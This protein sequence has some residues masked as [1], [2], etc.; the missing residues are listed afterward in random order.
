MRE[1]LL[2]LIVGCGQT[3]LET[4]NSAKKPMVVLNKY[5]KSCGRFST[6]YFLL[7][8]DSANNHLKVESGDLYGIYEIGDTIK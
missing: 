4:V 2:F 8:K 6:C 1:D 3:A 5:T 7:L